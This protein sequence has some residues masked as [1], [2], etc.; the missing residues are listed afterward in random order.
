MLIG[1]LLAFM[2]T[3][4]AW[5]KF[6]N[7]PTFTTLILNPRGMKIAYPTTTVCP[8]NSED[9]RKV[10]EFMNEFEVAVNHSK[11]INELLSAIPN[12]SYGRQGLKS[13][14][15]STPVKHI[16]NEIT[17]FDL[18]ALAFEL[19]ISCSK[20][21]KTCLF[22]KKPINCCDNFLPVFSEHGF[23]YAFNSRVYSTPHDE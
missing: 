19:A 16:V 13:L 5:E 23:C 6:Q 22:R 7:N 8:H 20:L 14:I 1:F 3:D 18:R 2:V 10:V 9:P 21:I 15:S 4:K 12:F 11:E 17:D